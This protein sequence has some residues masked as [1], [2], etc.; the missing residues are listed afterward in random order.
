MR[1]IRNKRFVFKLVHLFCMLVCMS[2]ESTLWCRVVDETG[3]GEL[4]VSKILRAASSYS[5]DNEGE[6][7]ESVYE[8]REYINFVYSQKD[9]LRRLVW[10]GPEAS[11]YDDILV[12]LPTDAG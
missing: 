12:L 4:L 10:M 11:E 9:V 7:P 1:C 2:S 5:D 3:G 6:L 8:L